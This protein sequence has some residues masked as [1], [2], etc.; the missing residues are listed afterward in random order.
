[1]CTKNDPGVARAEG[2]NKTVVDG[3]DVKRFLPRSLAVDFVC[4]DE[5]WD[6]ARIASQLTADID[7]P[8][9]RLRLT[10]T[11]AVARRAAQRMADFYREPIV[12]CNGCMQ[13]LAWCKPTA[14]VIP[15]PHNPTKHSE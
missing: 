2:Q 12:I 4:D 15:A 5:T 11:R 13:V 8:R 7:V 9:I 10:V 6:I 1:M 14:E 3:N